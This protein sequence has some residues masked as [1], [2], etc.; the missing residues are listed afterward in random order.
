M[1]CSRESVA[2][3]LGAGLL[4]MRAA[5]L[6]DRSFHLGAS[7]ACPNRSRNRVRG[8]DIIDARSD[9]RDRLTTETGI[10]ER[11]RAVHLRRGELVRD[12]YP[13]RLREEVLERT[14]GFDVHREV[15]FRDG[16]HEHRGR[17]LKSFS[18]PRERFVGSLLCGHRCYARQSNDRHEQRHSHVIKTMMPSLQPAGARQ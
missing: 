18:D 17:L 15:R 4:A 6:G 11:V 9:Y 2:N 8:L 10:C 3:L 1:T 12:R 16:E 7:R 5:V 14:A 13:R